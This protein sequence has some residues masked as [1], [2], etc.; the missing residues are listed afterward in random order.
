MILTVK[1]YKYCKG[2]IH[3]S[4]NININLTIEPTTPLTIDT[5]HITFTK[6]SNYKP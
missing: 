2:I 6:K 3:G 1:A 4:N 5:N